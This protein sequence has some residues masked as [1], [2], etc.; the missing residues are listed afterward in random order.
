MTTDPEVEQ[1]VLIDNSV[2]DNLEHDLKTAIANENVLMDTVMKL[3]V[4]L[5]KVKRELMEFK[6]MHDKKV[7]ELEKEN[8]DL[9]QVLESHN[10]GIQAVLAK[11]QK[12]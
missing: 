6:A 12:I 7:A 5:D 10:V 2:V 3:Q 11:I 4:E 8:N 9:K 1:F